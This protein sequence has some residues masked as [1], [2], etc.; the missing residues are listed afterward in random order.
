MVTV[1]VTRQD[2]KHGWDWSYWR[3]QQKYGKNFHKVERKR[4]EFCPVA[5]ALAR[6]FG[7]KSIAETYRLHVGGVV[8]RCPEVVSDWMYDFDNGM[9]VQPFSFELDNENPQGHP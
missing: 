5:I 3:L 6:T 9:D 4:C 8:Y 1:E 7:Q 2:I